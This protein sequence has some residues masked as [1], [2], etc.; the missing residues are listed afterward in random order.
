MLADVAATPIL[1]TSSAEA[2][3]LVL[4]ATCNRQRQEIDRLS[5]ER[6]GLATANQELV[7][8]RDELRRRLGLNSTNS[9]KPPTMSTCQMDMRRAPARDD[10]LRRW[11]IRERLVDESR[12]ARVSI[13]EV[14]LPDGVHFEADQQDRG[15]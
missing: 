2:L 11:K 12:M 15:G 7:R 8:E 10:S 9:S 13:A 1:R 4:L 5:E 3:A 14:E 6:N